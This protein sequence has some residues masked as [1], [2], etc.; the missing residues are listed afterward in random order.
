MEVNTRAAAKRK[1]ARDLAIALCAALFFLQRHAVVFRR[2]DGWGNIIF[3]LFT[4][5]QWKE[6]HD[7]SLDVDRFFYQI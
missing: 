4:P 6:S 2:S 1:R 5:V 7:E 3:I